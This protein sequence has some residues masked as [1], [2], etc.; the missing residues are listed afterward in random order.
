MQREIQWFK[1]VESRMLHKDRFVINND[2]HTAHFLFTENHRELMEKGEKW[3]KETS[4]SCMVVASLI[5]TVAFAAAIT[6]PGGNVQDNNS[7]DN[8]LPVFL[9]KNS[10]KRIHLWSVVSR[11]KYNFT[12][13]LH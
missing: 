2:G 3:M 8:G 9:K 10:F 12:F 4:T 1:R 7:S 5:A 6:V 13:L 11:H